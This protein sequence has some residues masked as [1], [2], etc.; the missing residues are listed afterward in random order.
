MIALLVACAAKS[1][2]PGR[3]L[4]PSCGSVMPQ[5]GMKVPLYCTNTPDPAYSVPTV[6][7]PL[8]VYTGVPAKL[9]APTDM[10]YDIDQATR[11]TKDRALQRS[12]M[13]SYVQAELTT[14]T[15]AGTALAVLLASPGVAAWAS[16]EIAAGG[17]TAAQW[18]AASGSSAAILALIDKL[19]PNM[20]VYQAIAVEAKHEQIRNDENAMGCFDIYSQPLSKMRSVR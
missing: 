8:I 20:N 6:W 1:Q 16:S 11:C 14:T 7:V 12:S 2:I 13:R 10:Y 4:S 19:N 18:Q 9:Y 15:F 17:F 5:A 3:A